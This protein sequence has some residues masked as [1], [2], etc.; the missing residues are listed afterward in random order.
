MFKISGLDKFRPIFS[1]VFEHRYF[2][3]KNIY[4]FFKNPGLFI[5]DEDGSL[6]KLVSGFGYAHSLW[7]IKGRILDSPLKHLKLSYVE[8]NNDN[9]NLRGGY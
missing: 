7:E 1:V 5:I 2:L 3:I 8:I 4:I 9:G 6:C